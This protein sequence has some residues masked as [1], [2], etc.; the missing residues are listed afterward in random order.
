MVGDTWTSP[1]S[2]ISLIDYV[3]GD[4]CIL[5]MF[6]H[7]TLVSQTLRLKRSPSAWASKFIRENSA[8]EG[9]RTEMIPLLAITYS[10]LLLCRNMGRVPQK[11]NLHLV[12]TLRN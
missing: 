6:R 11:Q 1:L 2:V 8:H 12:Y 7:V 3:G 9:I 10:H 5:E 4:E